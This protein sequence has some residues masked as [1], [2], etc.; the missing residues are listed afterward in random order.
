MY[1]LFYC[2]V[3]I[4]ATNMQQPSPQVWN[5][6]CQSTSELELYVRSATDNSTL[7]SSS[8]APSQQP[9]CLICSCGQ[10][11]SAA[12]FS[13][14]SHNC[15]SSKVLVSPA[16]LAVWAWADFKCSNLWQSWTAVDCSLSLSKRQWKATGRRASW[17]E[18]TLS[19][20]F[21]RCSS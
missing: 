17:V 12:F 15:R 19:T 13:S 1:V 11:I 3:N 20:S 5:K 6:S 21:L 4:F 2:Q 10:A 7:P 14:L 9:S 18:G 8:A 16:S